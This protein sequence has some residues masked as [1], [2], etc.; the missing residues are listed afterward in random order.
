MIELLEGFIEKK[1]QV[2]KQNVP[3]CISGSNCYLCISPRQFLFT[4]IILE[5]MRRKKHHD[6]PEKANTDIADDV[7][8]T[9]SNKYRTNNFK[10]Q[11]AFFKRIVTDM[12]HYID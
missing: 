12:S 10:D 3:Y 11:L 8:D 1:E 7:H 5:Q 4:C 2:Y 9:H 6:I